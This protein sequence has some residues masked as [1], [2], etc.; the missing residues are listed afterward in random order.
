MHVF[1]L[2]QGAQPLCGFVLV[3]HSG[4]LLPDIERLLAHGKQ[5]GYVL[6][7]DDVALAEAGV[8]CHAPDDLRH[9]VTQNVA[10][11]LGRFDKL[12]RSI[13]FPA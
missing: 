12:H 2:A 9:V 7:T 3:Q 10:D 6:F 1:P 11:G 5:N 8:L 13:L 4:S